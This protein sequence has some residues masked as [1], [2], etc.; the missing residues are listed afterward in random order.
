[1][2]QKIL[3]RYVWSDFHPLQKYP[4]FDYG[5][6]NSPDP[7]GEAHTAST[8]A[9]TFGSPSFKMLPEPLPALYYRK[10]FTILCS[11][12]GTSEDQHALYCA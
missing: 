8:G 12:H 6:A 9:L 2:L 4:Y 3:L 1:M 7:V 11:V 10:P 5:L